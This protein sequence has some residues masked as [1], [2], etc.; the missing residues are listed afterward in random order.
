MV[1]PSYLHFTGK[2]RGYLK[3]CKN[4]FT[5]F[6]QRCPGQQY[7]DCTEDIEYAVMGDFVNEN[8]VGLHVSMQ[9]R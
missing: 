5:I 3:V 1:H 6:Y 9:T 7:K 2:Y 4:V 8:P